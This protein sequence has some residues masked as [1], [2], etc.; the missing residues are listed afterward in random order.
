MS[1]I[2]TLLFTIPSSPPTHLRSHSSFQTILIR[3]SL[4]LVKMSGRELLVMGG[5]L[6]IGP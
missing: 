1:P 3:P 2:Y 5:R 6:E 4:F